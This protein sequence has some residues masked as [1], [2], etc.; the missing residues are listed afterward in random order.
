MYRTLVN[1]LFEEETLHQVAMVQVC[2]ST[3]IRNLVNIYEYL[4]Y[5]LVHDLVHHRMNAG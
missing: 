5:Q 4:L 2:L 3:V 1:Y